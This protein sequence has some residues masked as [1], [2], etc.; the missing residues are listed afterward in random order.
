MFGLRQLSNF[1]TGGCLDSGDQV[2]QEEGKIVILL[3]Q[4]NPGGR[5]R[6][7]RARR[8]VDPTLRV[9]PRAGDDLRIPRSRQPLPGNPRTLEGRQGSRKRRPRGYDALHQL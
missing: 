1:A 5:A 3:I 2:G 9:S 4:R 8:P 6:N 7:G